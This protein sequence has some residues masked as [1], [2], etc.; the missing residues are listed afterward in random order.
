MDE[1]KWYKEIISKIDIVPEN[2]DYYEKLAVKPGF[3]FIYALIN[4]NR[5]ALGTLKIFIPETLY[6]NYDSYLLY[7]DAQGKIIVK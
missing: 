6:F 7:S 4:C 2:I 3:D 1:K 5:E